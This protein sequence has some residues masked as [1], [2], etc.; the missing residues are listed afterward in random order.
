MNYTEPCSGLYRAFFQSLT[1]TQLNI[2]YRIQSVTYKLHLV[3]CVHLVVS[4]KSC[5]NEPPLLPDPQGKGKNNK[6][7]GV[8]WGGTN[9][10]IALVPLGSPTP[11][12]SR[13]VWVSVSQQGP[14]PQNKSN[15]TTN[16]YIYYI[17][18]LK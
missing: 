10:P 15:E 5:H 4:N 11:D 18:I 12:G 2:K 7:T 6:N 8:G 16:I 14:S 3:H 17:Q 13:P 1:Y 9:H